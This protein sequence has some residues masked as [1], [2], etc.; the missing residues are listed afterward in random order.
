M[1]THPIFE[2]DFDCLTEK[3][4]GTMNETDLLGDVSTVSLPGNDT[5]ANIET[6]LL[7]DE[8]K[9]ETIVEERSSDYD[10]GEVTFKLPQIA[11]EHSSDEL[12]K[13]AIATDKRDRDEKLAERLQKKLVDPQSPSNSPM[14]KK[15]KPED[16]DVEND[17]Q[18]LPVPKGSYNMEFDKFDDPNFNPF[19]T[20]TKVQN[21]FDT[22]AASATTTTSPVAANE[23]P[24]SKEEET[25]VKETT[26]EPGDE[27]LNEL[28]A[29]FDA[30]KRKPP[31]LGK[32][33]KPASAKKTTQNK[34]PVMPS[35]P[36]DSVETGEEETLPP[37]KGAYA[38][39]FDK[40]DDPNFNPFETKTKVVDK[41]EV[42]KIAPAEEVNT[43]EEVV[44]DNDV[45]ATNELN[46]TF[47]PPKRKPP[48]LGKNR[49]PI[50]KKVT[51]PKPKPVP[52]PPSA[53]VDDEEAPLP[54]TGAYAIDFDKCWWF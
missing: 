46:T 19:E 27:A 13:P 49:K 29:T 8:T 6:D 22:D 30:P 26:D 31:V 17:E 43:V 3:P 1:G 4:D 36:K 15:M 45:G 42:E 47:E 7:M 25:P 21:N 18:P 53:T 10:D 51:A 20:K 23:E 14:V 5:L 39:D 2:S 35:P 52:P 44:N 40:F 33:R 11:K 50:K 24:V 41:F 12:P 16:K 34:K 38:V 37:S 54:K 48:T 32:N 9:T 28:N